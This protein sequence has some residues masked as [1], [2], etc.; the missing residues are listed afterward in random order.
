MGSFWA[1]TEVKVRTGVP[2]LGAKAW[3]LLS[4]EGQRTWL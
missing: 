1:R 2:Q 3:L 4:K